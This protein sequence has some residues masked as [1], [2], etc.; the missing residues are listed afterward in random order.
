MDGFESIFEMQKI[1]FIVMGILF[2]VIFSFAIAMIFSS[3]LRGKMMSNQVKAMKHMTDMSKDD[4]EQISTTL[5]DVAVNV[6]SNV[7]NNNEEIL[8]NIANKQADINKDAVKT[9]FTA[10]KEGLQGDATMFCKY[11]GESIDVDSKFC[12]KCGKMQ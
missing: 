10:I 11:C 2:V 1:M 4:I 3:K 6:K 7:I 12:K 9:T 8:R 5:G